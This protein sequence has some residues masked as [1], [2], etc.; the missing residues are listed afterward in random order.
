[1]A[2]PIRLIS[3][4]L[5]LQSLDRVIGFSL[6]RVRRSP[7]PALYGGGAPFKKCSAYWMAHG[8]V[9]AAGVR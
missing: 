8:D 4:I 1:M 2:Q 9:F 6:L 3:A 5:L 7:A